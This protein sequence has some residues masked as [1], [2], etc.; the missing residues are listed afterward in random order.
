MMFKS[1]LYEKAANWLAG[2]QGKISVLVVAGL[3]LLLSFFDIPF[4][5]IDAAWAAIVLAGVPIV[6]GA[7]IAVAAEGDIKADLLVS[8]ALIAAVIVGEYFAAGEIAVIMQIGAFLEERT[9]AGAQAGIAELV[10]LTPEKAHRILENGEREDIEAC[11]IQVGDM[12]HVLPGEKVPTDGAVI[13]GHS[14]IDTSVLTG[15]SIPV[16]IAAGAEVKSGTLNQYGS[17]TMRASSAAEESS[18]ARLVRL[19]EAAD[20]GKTRIVRMADKWATV[21]VVLALLTATGTYF[22]TGEV[23]RAVTIL[24]VFCPCALVLA[25][26]TAVMAAIGNAAKHGFLVKEGDA[27]ERLAEVDAIAFDKTRTLTVGRPAVC[28]S[29]AAKSGFSEED[30]LRT[31]GALEAASEHPLG[32]AIAAAAKERGLLQQETVSTKCRVIAGEGIVSEG[33]ERTMMAGN[34]RLIERYGTGVSAEAKAWRE[35][36]LA[37]G[38]TLVY[39]AENGDLLGILSLSDQL[40]EEAPEAVRELQERHLRTVML[41]GD[42]SAAAMHI[43]QALH[44]DEIAAECLPENKLER[45]RAVE[46]TG[47]RIVMLGDGINDAPALKRAHISIA[48]GGH[49]SD[50]A[51]GAADIAIT[52]DS[53]AEL[54]HLF[55]LSRKLMTTIRWN[56][57]FAFTLNFV[58]I[59]LAAAG[60]MGP[61]AGELIHNAG[62]VVVIIRSALLLRWR[63]HTKEA[64]KPILLQNR[65]QAS[66]MVT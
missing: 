40:R 57:I 22:A 18:I 37:R 17:F 34:L 28:G 10:A 20:A 29:F 15:E 43:G 60:E 1:N 55:D 5:G 41:T 53:L 12:I 36:V 13:S 30:L 25:T 66:T 14:S 46:E 2:P 24:V 59:I 31:A 27:L 62:S 64:E 61:V 7:A 33:D 50:I 23:L 39:L 9:V 48:M 45:I 16:D 56:L 4:C 54:P 58:A 8:L 65:R 52:R 32:K 51:I 26:P 21:I 11:E 47:H 49:G 38:E 44:F 3:S 63:L 42:Q 6:R 19:V 35:A